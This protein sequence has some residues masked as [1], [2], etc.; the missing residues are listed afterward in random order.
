MCMKVCVLGC[1]CVCMLHDNEIT[2]PCTMMAGG[3]VGCWVAMMRATVF[4]TTQHCRAVR[5][6]LCSFIQLMLSF[7][8][9]P[10]PAY[11]CVAT[12]LIA[13]NSAHLR[14]TQ[15]VVTWNMPKLYLEIVNFQLQLQKSVPTIM[16]TLLKPCQQQK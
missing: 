13:N 8:I 9:P 11:L 12:L 10:Q 14:P 15:L 7:G 3:L 2:C 16:F 4:A 1:K 5:C 6:L